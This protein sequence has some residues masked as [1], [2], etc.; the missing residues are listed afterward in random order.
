M[1]VFVAIISF[2]VVIGVGEEA[3]PVAGFSAFL[4]YCF[5]CQ[6]LLSRGNVDAHRHWPIM[7]TLPVAIV[8]LMILGERRE[9]ILFQGLGILTSGS[10][11][12]YAGA[13]AAA[14]HAR[15]APAQASRP[16]RLFS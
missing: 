1:K 13:V 16:P 14:I 6:F 10:G 7:L 9:V 15:R 8:A 3:G 11:G 5:V 4:A 2:V 12:A